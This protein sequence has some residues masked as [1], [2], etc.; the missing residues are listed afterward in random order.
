MFENLKQVVE[1]FGGQEF[2]I[3]AIIL[4]VLF[5][6]VWQVSKYIER[7]K[8]INRKVE[9]NSGQI[10]RFNGAE[11]RIGRVEKHV[12]AIETSTKNNLEKIISIGG[13]ID[14]IEN[15]LDLIFDWVTPK[16]VAKEQ[17]PLNL[18]SF[19]NKIKKEIKGDLIVEKYKS[20]ISVM[21]DKNNSEN[22]PYDIQQKSRR[23]AEDEL[24]KLLSKKDLETIKGTAFNEGIP[25]FQVYKVLGLLIRDFILEKKVIELKS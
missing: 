23:I 7:F 6:T 22:N 3:L 2:S 21:F 9:E 18:T 11:K 25:V 10:E 5:Y 16:R 14:S 24:P 8:G 20:K 4:C 12:K 17:S 15:K 1:Y 19:G 13:K